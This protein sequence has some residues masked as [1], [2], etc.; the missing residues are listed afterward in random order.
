MTVCG[1]FVMTDIPDGQ[2]DDIVVGYKE[3][4]PPPISVTKKQDPDGTWTVMA[5]W[6]ACNAGTTV[7]HSANNMT[8]NDGGG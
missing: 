2:Q 5:E 8:I 7:T 1:S 4:I 6:P 3:N